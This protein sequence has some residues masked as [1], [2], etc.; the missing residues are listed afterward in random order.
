MAVKDFEIDPIAK[1]VCSST[2]VEA[3]TLRVP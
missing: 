3:P 2:G 1:R